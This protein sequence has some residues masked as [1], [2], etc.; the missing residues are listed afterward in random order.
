MA[1]PIKRNNH[2]ID[3]TGK[4]LGRLASEVAILLRGKN[5]PSFQ[6]HVDGGDIVQITNI[7]HVKVTGNKQEQKKYF[8]YTGYPGGIKS[9][10]LDELLESNPEKLMKMVVRGM[11]PDN[12]LRD[13]MLKR[14]TIK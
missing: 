8:R 5:K 12:K 6:P 11:L 7:K 14:L 13:G 9:S 2:V 4:S 3:A 1:T 10:T